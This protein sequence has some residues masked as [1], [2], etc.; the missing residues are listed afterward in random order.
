MPCQAELGKKGRKNWLLPAVGQWTDAA[1]IN[2][3]I[4][5][6]CLNILTV[7]IFSFLRFL[8]ETQKQLPARRRTAS[9][10]FLGYRKSMKTLLMHHMKT[11][12]PFMC[13]GTTDFLQ[14]ACFTVCKSF[15]R[16]VSVQRAV[17]WLPLC[18]SPSEINNHVFFLLFGHSRHSNLFVMDSSSCIFVLTTSYNLLVFTGIYL[19]DC[20]FRLKNSVNFF[21]CGRF[22]L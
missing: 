16:T 21:F 11:C 2:V 22:F 9:P 19:H 3:F 4:W 14:L 13:L 15:Y 7:F 10:F 1:S 18:E 20:I 6:R 12:T 17:Q 5:A 8:H